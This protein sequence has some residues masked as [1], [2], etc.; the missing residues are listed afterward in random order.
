MS[1]I[2]F[3][4]YVDLI[5]SGTPSSGFSVAYDLDGVLKQKDFNGVITPI[6][7]TASG[8][9]V[10]SPWSVGSGTY[11]IKAINDSGLDALGQYSTVQGYGTIASG[12]GSHAEGNNS[13]AIGNYS[14]SEG[15]GT[16]AGWKAFTVTSVFSG[17]ITIS[18]NVDY[19][20]E[21]TGYL[22]ILDNSSYT[23]NSIN[24]SSP[25]FSIQLDDT[26]INN[27][28]YVADIFNLNSN[29][30]TNI[31]GDYSSSKG[32]DTRATGYASNAEGLETQA[33]GDVS[34]AE[35]A[36]TKASGSNS[37]AEGSGSKA[38]GVNSHAEGRGTI[39]SGD[40]SHSEGIFTKSTG[41]YS[42]AEGGFATSSGPFSHA[43][44][45]LTKTVGYSSH[46]EGMQ[47]ITNGDF[48]HAEGF[49]TQAGWKAFRTSSVIS[50]LI[51]ISDNIDYSSEFLGSVV[52]LDNNLYT[53]T[54]PTFS[55]PNFT[56]Q[57]D[58]TSIN[59][60]DYVADLSNLNSE[61]T[62][63]REGYISHSEGYNTLST[64]MS[65]HAE[66]EST[67][68]SGIGSHAEGE[69]TLASGHYSHSGGI[70]TK[71]IGYGSFIHGYGST[72]SGTGSIVLGDGIDGTDDNK[73]YVSNLNIKNIGT[74]T[75]V[76]NLG[77]DID[78]N[79]T[80]STSSIYPYKIYSAL[81]SQSGALSPTAIELENTLG[82]TA[83]FSYMGPGY[84]ELHMSGK[85]TSGKTFIINGWPD[86]D[87]IG[88]DFG[89]FI[90]TYFNSSIVVL[91]TQDVSGTST[92]SNG[93]LNN[94]SIE[95][96]VY[97]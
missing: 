83:T 46:T 41:D 62:N 27:G 6:G 70:D 24:F 28:Y 25:T 90:T 48:S 55:S 69:G 50:G 95:I 12:D 96:R 3:T 21:F 15:A 53:Y 75:S 8:L 72:A 79:V 17:L 20:S 1:L 31:L 40:G 68:A 64:G 10:S 81:L 39:A 11:S 4:T 52:L 93:L 78:G 13:K 32:L 7:S 2:N 92:P 16:N 97:P 9:T 44:G 38:S 58:D 33:T 60:G 84:Y 29:L 18:D 36:N 26:S 5:N 59:S 86:Q 56:I 23:Y 73:V 57:L 74:S 49:S 82:I 77:V 42:H 66:G 94:T 63:Y 51:T 35:G 37:H 47:T 71:A 19:S 65:S 14:H 45:Y 88:G 91:K 89:I 85:F 43:E 34:H 54:S 22:L 87:A 76:I 61:L 67:M 30:A 80:T